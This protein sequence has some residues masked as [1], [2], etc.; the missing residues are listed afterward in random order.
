MKI[1]KTDIKRIRKIMDKNGFYAE[2]RKK[3]KKILI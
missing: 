2:E 1:V 3:V